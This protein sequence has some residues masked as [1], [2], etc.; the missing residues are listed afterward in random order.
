MAPLRG[1]RYFV[2]CGSEHTQPSGQTNNL[3]ERLEA[4]SVAIDERHRLSMDCSLSDW[5]SSKIPTKMST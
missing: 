1:K 3:A 4:P 2:R 5:V